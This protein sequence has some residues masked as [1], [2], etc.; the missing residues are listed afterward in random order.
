MDPIST[1]LNSHLSAL[2]QNEQPCKLVV[3]LSGGVDSVVL[4]HALSRL[5]HQC[6]LPLPETEAV[7]VNHGLSP[8]AD[9]W[10]QF[11]QA[12]CATLGLPF[13][14]YTVEV[15]PG[16]RESLEACARERR[17]EALCNHAKHHQGIILTAHH[18]DDQVE[19]VLLQL[20]RG[21]GP[22]GLSGIPAMNNMH[23]VIV[24]RPLLTVSREQI[25]D[26]AHRYSLRW[27][28][29][30]SN[31]DETF[32]RN[33]LRQTIIP[34]LMSRWPSLAQ[35]VSRSAHLCAEQQTL[36]DEVC[37]ER[38]KTL[39][40][41][42]DRINV[43][44]LKAAS[45]RWQRVLLRRWLE[46][47]QIAMPGIKQLE[48]IL[49]MIEARP[50]AQPLVVLGD[51]ELRRYQNQIYCLRQRVRSWSFVSLEFGLHET[52]TIAPIG[53]NLRINDDKQDEGFA[54]NMTTQSSVFSLTRP[55]L[56]RMIK[57][58]GEAYHKPLK[59]WLKH[60]SVPPWERDDW[61]LL[62]SEE[63]PLALVTIGKLIL[64]AASGNHTVF[65]HLGDS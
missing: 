13:A 54:I 11:C 1:A 3:A 12:F 15:S 14:A 20:K 55:V 35:T 2:I 64:L 58:A 57:P 24:S 63:E 36:L 37:D 59:Q 65:V 62:S 33:F 39:C 45:L 7:Y 22:K 49:L 10:Q 52:V 6:E 18:L 34:P 60:W 32:D 16:N 29:D 48:Q 43:Q 61:L 25:R 38:L 40:T 53:L 28:E 31:I 47:N 46:L 44:A 23:S 17:Y 42:P 21:A 4:L 51:S 9:A 26:Y 50:D 19:T 41:Q 27:I 5:S 8:N 30:E 56:S